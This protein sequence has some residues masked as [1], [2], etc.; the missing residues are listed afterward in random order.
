MK[1]S[2][3]LTYYGHIFRQLFPKR[4][5]TGLLCF[6]PIHVFFLPRVYSDGTQV[7]TI[8]I[9][10]FT[11]IIDHFN[12]FKGQNHGQA[13]SVISRIESFGTHGFTGTMYPSK[14]RVH[15]RTKPSN[16]QERQRTSTWR[17]HSHS[18]RIRKRSQKTEVGFPVVISV[19]VCSTLSSIHY[20]A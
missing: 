16:Y 20:M 2:H 10:Y 15:R 1:R 11:I 17:W 6:R 5:L 4:L 14:S 18:T 12:N 8:S 9:N 7:S 13:S 19:Y 3:S